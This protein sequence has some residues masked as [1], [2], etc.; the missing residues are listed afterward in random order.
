MKIKQQHLSEKNVQNLDLALKKIESDLPHIIE[1]KITKSRGRFL[2]YLYKHHK[3]KNRDKNMN[4]IR[5][6]CVLTVLHPDIV[7]K[8]LM[9]IELCRSEIEFK[10]SIFKSDDQEDAMREALLQ[11]YNTLYRLHY[12]TQNMV[13]DGCIKLGIRTS[14]QKLFLIRNENTIQ[15][16]WKIKKQK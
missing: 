3:V 6:E 7:I 1:E 14:K 11:L 10:E 13:V 15:L 12:P 2:F 4:H 5:R 9:W 8:P 16:G